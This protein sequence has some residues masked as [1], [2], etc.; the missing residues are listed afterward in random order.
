MFNLKVQLL[1]YINYKF[2]LALVAF[3][4]EVPVKVQTVQWRIENGAIVEV[5]A[6]IH[7]SDNRISF[8]DGS[9]T[10]SFRN[11]WEITGTHGTIRIK[12]FCD[13][14]IEDG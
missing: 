13:G 4:F 12:K 11:N 1:I 3:G 8:I 2:L 14:G 7:F 10:E 5:S 6:V 9:F